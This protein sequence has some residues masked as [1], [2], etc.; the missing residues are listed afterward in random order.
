VPERER[1]LRLLGLLVGHGTDI[2]TSRLCEVSAEAT[3]MSGAGIMLMSEDVPRGSICTTDET[4]ARIEELQFTLG[5]GPSVDAYAQDRPVVEPHLARASRP[6]W[7]AFTPAA[8]EVGAEAV[9]SFP[10]H[11]G[12][13]RLGS[14]NLYCDRPGGLTDDQHADALVMADVAAHAVLLLQANAPPGTLAEE[15][16]AGG[17][18]R[19]VVHQA[20]G[21]TAAQLDISIARALIQLRAYAFAND[22]PLAEVADEIVA[23]TLRLDGLPAD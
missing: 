20:S 18:F 17:E 6:R 5:E 15:L 21:M 11:V 12:A 13:V 4:S 9:F 19:F 1:R 23:R 8:L 22:R 14:L 3:G 16:E 10:L 7:L 2:Q